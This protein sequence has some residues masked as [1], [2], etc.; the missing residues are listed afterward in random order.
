MRTH[1]HTHT[2]PLTLPQGLSLR[3]EKQVVQQISKLRSQRGRVKEYDSQKSEL[4]ELESESSKVSWFIG[5]LLC[6]HVGGCAIQG[7]FCALV[8]CGAVIPGGLCALL[9][10]CV[11]T[12]ALFSGESIHMSTTIQHHHHTRARAHTHTHTCTHTH[13]HARAHIHTRRSRRSLMIWMASSA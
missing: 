7:G 8:I 4:A 13:T 6:Q 11:H 1:T 2:H 3:E 5:W 12:Y 9:R 10:L